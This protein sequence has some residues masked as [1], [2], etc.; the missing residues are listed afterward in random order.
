MRRVILYRYA[1]GKGRVTV[2]PEMPDG[3]HSQTF[4][5]I[6]DEG[7][8]LTS[9]GAVCGCVDTDSPD[10]WTELPDEAAYAEA[11]KILM[12]VSE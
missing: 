6:A 2:S 5:L 7:C 3:E 4:R 9:G 10:E 1:D 8:V 12:G 11:G